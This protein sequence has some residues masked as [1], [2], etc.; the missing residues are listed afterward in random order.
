[1]LSRKIALESLCHPGVTKLIDITSMEWLIFSAAIF[2]TVSILLHLVSILMA[3]GRFYKPTAEAPVA[4]FSADV[5]I[6]RPVCGVE[7]FIEETL[8]STFRLDHSRYEILFCVASGSD[9]AIALVQRLIA[10]HPHIPARLLVGNA[11]INANPKLNNM[12]KGWDAARGDWVVMADSNVLMPP[13]YIQR[14]F[15]AWRADTGLVCSPPVGCAPQGLWAELECAILNTHQARWQCFAD[16]AGFGYAQGK[17]MLWRRDFLAAAGGIRALASEVA[18]DAAA[19]KLVRRAGLSVHLVARPFEQPLGARRAADVWRRQIRWARLRR[20]TFPLLFAPEIF[21]GGLFPLLALL[22]LAAAAGW[23]LA[24]ALI[25]FSLVWYGAEA[26]L[27]CIAGWH[28]VMRSP[29]IWLARDL[30]LPA[31]W[32]SSLVGNSF[33]WR[34]NNMRVAASERMS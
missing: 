8:R 34:G 15:H 17:T 6:I 28:L 19:T 9:P 29:A 14:L 22:F 24:I 5:T 20:D 13:D 2:L 4:P 32:L 10:E 30:L 27:A 21:V 23:P 3:A 26:V 12:V 1:M 7:N 11:A 33:E 18:E 25:A 16:S 31:I